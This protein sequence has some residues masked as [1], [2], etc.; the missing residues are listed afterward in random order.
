MLVKYLL[1]LLVV[2]LAVW[3]LST[4][5]RRRDEAD[6]PPKPPG[7]AAKVPAPLDMVACAHC[8]LHLPAADAV[9]GG[10]RVFCSEAHRALGLKDP[11]SA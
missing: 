6:A 3:M 1:V 2:G 11:G 9:L 5:F 7:D 10:S 4:K 8:G